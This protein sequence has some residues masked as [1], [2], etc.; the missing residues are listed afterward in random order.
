MSNENQDRKSRIKES[1]LDTG[2]EC[3]TEYGNNFIR[4]YMPVAL[5]WITARIK[6]ILSYATSKDKQTTCERIRNSVFAGIEIGEQNKEQSLVMAMK[7][8]KMDEEQI[9]LIL[10]TSKNYLVTKEEVESE[11]QK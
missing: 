3:I 2:E 7:A 8:L 10:D 11:M 4:T 9:A 1:F 6:E 5:D